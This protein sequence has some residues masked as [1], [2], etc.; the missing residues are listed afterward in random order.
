MWSDF[1]PALLRRVSSHAI[2]PSVLPGRILA[3]KVK[4]GSPAGR[5]PE[6]HA[7]WRLSRSWISP[8]FGLRQNSWACPRSHSQ[9]GPRRDRFN[10]DFRLGSPPMPRAGCGATLNLVK[11]AR[12]KGPGD[13]NPGF[14][15]FAL[16]L[17]PEPAPNPAPDPAR[18]R[19]G[20]LIGSLGYMCG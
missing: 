10:P 17:E 20:P 19:G 1:E 12:A 13:L 18:D 6:L 3:G 5:R 7:W 2:L 9:C 11:I 16:G 4:I 15:P 8:C 14:G